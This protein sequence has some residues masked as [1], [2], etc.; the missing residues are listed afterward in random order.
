MRQKDDFSLRP[1]G[2]SPIYTPSTPYFAYN[3]TGDLGVDSQW[4][5]VD[6]PVVGRTLQHTS[7][8]WTVE[9]ALVSKNDYGDS[10]VS[11][12]F[13]HEHDNSPVNAYDLRA[14]LRVGNGGY[15]RLWI[16][17]FSSNINITVVKNSAIV[18]SQN[19]IPISVY[20]SRTLHR[21]NFRVEKTL[22]TAQMLH[23]D[24]ELWAIQAHVPELVDGDGNPAWQARFWG[25][26][27][28]Q[29]Y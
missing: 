4:S 20:F 24:E 9:G 15:I 21:C 1:L 19:Y 27:W 12:D 14:Y 7:F 18:F 13:Y 10:E 11:F 16:N 28:V 6:H 26:G 17:R 8:F 3:T 5:I 29:W 2:W 23:G 25:M 22:I